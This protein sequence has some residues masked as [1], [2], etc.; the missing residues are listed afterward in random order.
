MVLTLSFEQLLQLLLPTLHIAHCATTKYNHI[1]FLVS[2]QCHCP[3]R[4]NKIFYT[5]DPQGLSDG[6]VILKDL[7][8]LAGFLCA[9]IVMPPPR[10]HPLSTMTGTLFWKA[11]K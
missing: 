7:T 5:D 9:E 6:K 3:N 4:I 10:K 11:N 2:C 8:Q 1:Q